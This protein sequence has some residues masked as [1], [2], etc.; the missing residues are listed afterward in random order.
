MNAVGMSSKHVA[1]VVSAFRP[2][3]TA[4]TNLRIVAEQVDDVFV[5]DDTG[6]GDSTLAAYGLVDGSGRQVHVPA[7]EDNLGLAT[8]LDRGVM[9]ALE[10]GVDYV[11]TLDQNTNLPARYAE[12]LV[13]HLDSLRER[14]YQAL[15]VASEFV[16]SVPY[17]QV[18]SRP[19]GNWSLVPVHS[20][21]ILDSRAFAMFCKFR[22][23]FSRDGIESDFLSRMNRVGYHVSLPRSRSSAHSWPAGQ[24][25]P[26]HAPFRRCYAA[27]LG[28]FF[29]LW[30]IETMTGRHVLASR[31]RTRALFTSTAVGSAIGVAGI[32]IGARLT[33][34]NGA[35]VSLAGALG[36]IVLS[37]GIHVAR[38]VSA[39]KKRQAN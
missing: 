34:T 15:V 13:H 31:G 23:G 18:H 39:E 33:G 19:E 29:L 35:A 16:D 20:G 3:E 14:G 22:E 38:L 9:R 6:T 28:V 12:E 30:S 25:R 5:V 8:S 10:L 32:W 24:A 37:Q 26:R 7:N 11:M 4:I 21:M 36:F 1:A 2:D 17:A 27:A